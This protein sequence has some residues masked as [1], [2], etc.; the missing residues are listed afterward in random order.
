[1]ISCRR[2]SCW[3]DVVHVVG[4]DEARVVTSCPARS[5]VPV[6][7]LQ[8]GDVVLL[9]LEEEVVRSKDVVI[10]VQLLAAGFQVPS[11]RSG[12]GSR[13]TCSRWCRSALRRARPGTRGR[14]VGN[15]K[16]P[17]TGRRWRS[18][19]GSCSRSRSRP[20]AA[21]GWISC[22]PAGRARSCVRGAR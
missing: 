18:A 13:Q 6:D 16:S 14:C 11:C 10:P 4:G 12:A 3:L 5:S 1:M 2:A 8:L 22:L 17:P 19:A 15:S 7:L 21:G 20:A 9:Q